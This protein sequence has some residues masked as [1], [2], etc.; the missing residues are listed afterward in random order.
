[1]TTAISIASMFPTVTGADHVYIVG[2]SSSEKFVQSQHLASLIGDV[3]SQ[4]ELSVLPVADE[5]WNEISRTLSQRLGKMFGEDDETIVFTSAGRLIGNEASFVKY[6]EAKYAMDLRVLAPSDANVARIASDNAVVVKRA[7]EL[8]RLNEISKGRIEQRR[9][10]LEAKRHALSGCLAVAEKA[11]DVLSSFAY[12]DLERSIQRNAVAWSKRALLQFGE[13]NSVSSEQL[14]DL[15]KDFVALQP[16]S[17][18]TQP[19]L[20][21]FK[22]LVGL[23]EASFDAATM[24]DLVEQLNDRLSSLGLQQADTQP[25]S[26]FLSAVRVLRQSL[27]RSCAQFCAKINTKILVADC[28]AFASQLDSIVETY[29]TASKAHETVIGSLKTK[30]DDVEAQETK[31]EQESKSLL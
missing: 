11:R 16:S 6:V 17:A 14:D 13:S 23:L 15:A 12:R 19:F 28:A 7:A 8:L 10:E 2:K 24:T 21:F 18:D 22:E 5:S 3:V 9:Q 29:V 27:A 26:L 20:N 31:V 25:H 1:M 30:L 4:V